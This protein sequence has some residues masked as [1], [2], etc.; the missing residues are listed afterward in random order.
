MKCPQ[1]PILALG[2]AH[3]GEAHEGGLAEIE[4]AVTI[5]VQECL[6][7]L[8]PLAFRESAPIE[9]LNW[10]L[11]SINYLLDGFRD[12]FPAETGAQNGVSFGHSLP[13]T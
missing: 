4:A 7:F 8:A 13:G 10:N 12:P 5:M 2:V 9:F 1:H 3:D 6:K 11:D